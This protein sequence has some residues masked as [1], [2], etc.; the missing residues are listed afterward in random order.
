[1]KPNLA[2][3]AK[4]IILANQMDRIISRIGLGASPRFRLNL[5]LKSNPFQNSS[6]MIIWPGFNAELFF[7]GENANETCLA[8]CL[9]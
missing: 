3:R 6:C 5:I 7:H 8:A 2:G 9:P 4:P 1:M